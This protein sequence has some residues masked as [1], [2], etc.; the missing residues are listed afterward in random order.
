VTGVGEKLKSEIEFLEL[1]GVLLIIP[2]SSLK[3]MIILND[4]S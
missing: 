3:K 4:Y 2:Q 1:D